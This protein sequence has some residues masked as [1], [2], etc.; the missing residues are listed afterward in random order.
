M[1]ISCPGCKS[2][3][4]VPDERIKAEGTKVKCGKCSKVFTVRKKS[5]AS[6]AAPARKSVAKAAAPATPPPAD[7]GSNPFT[8]DNFGAEMDNFKTQLRPMGGEREDDLFGD[9]ESL[10]KSPSRDASVDD[11]FGSAEDL[12][13]PDPETQAPEDPLGD[14]DEDPLDRFVA[15]IRG[16]RDEQSTEEE[17]EQPRAPSGPTRDE[18]VDDMFGDPMRDERGDDFDDML[19]E[20]PEPAARDHGSADDIDALFDDP[21]EDP[22]KPAIEK[23]KLDALFSEEEEAPAPSPEKLMEEVS[24]PSPEPDPKPEPS[25][26]EIGERMNLEPALTEEDA[27]EAPVENKVPP[28]KAAP[29][30]KLVS[31][32]LVVLL[33]LLLMV[34]GGTGL[35]FTVPEA[36]HTAEQLFARIPVDRVLALLPANRP[37]PPPPRPLLSAT[38]GQQQKVTGVRGDELYVVEGRVRNDYDGSR[39]FMQL[40]GY[41]YD[42]DDQVIAFRDVFAG[43]RLSI[44]E[45]RTVN[46]VRIDESLNRS[47]GDGLSNFNVQPGETIP[48]QIVFYDVPPEIERVEVEPIGS[49]PGS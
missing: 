37:E 10:S 13:P 44:N 18:S 46:R 35:F 21:G 14:S 6:G 38:V 7:D 2:R 27:P 49:E 41:L 36:R 9:S 11:L 47:V 8:G 23:D 20:A 28:K 25:P 33:I 12:A 5:A 45:I 43:N 32:R 40:R 30:R 31:K 24:S 34:G 48:F 22:E 1:Q 42:A 17:N 4:Q 39:S 19:D 15:D 16:T 3:I 29:R 26:E